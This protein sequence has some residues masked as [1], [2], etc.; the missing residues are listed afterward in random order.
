MA[1][2]C[3]LKVLWLV[4][5]L[6]APAAAHFRTIGPLY[7]GFFFKDETTGFVSADGLLYISFITDNHIGLNDVVLTCLHQLWSPLSF[8]TETTYVRL[9]LLA[10]RLGVGGVGQLPGWLEWQSRNGVSFSQWC[11]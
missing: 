1:V 11:L 3:E 9:S 8:S 5:R 2:F 7:Y 6:H 4:L 10:Y